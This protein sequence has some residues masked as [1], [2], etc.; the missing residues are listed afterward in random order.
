MLAFIFDRIQESR[1]RRMQAIYS[2]PSIPSRKQPT[3][4]PI[5]ILEPQEEYWRDSGSG[6]QSQ[7]LPPF[8][9]TCHLRHPSFRRP[10]LG[11]VGRV[12][13]LFTLADGGYP[14][15]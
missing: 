14:I 1:E 3:K 6:L 2:F 8:N 12:P 5:N 10:S 15:E 7:S 13:A 11:L 4:P 9:C